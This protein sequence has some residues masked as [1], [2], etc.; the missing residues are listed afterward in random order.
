MNFKEI[1]NKYLETIEVQDKLILM[2]EKTR[3]TEYEKYSQEI[4]NVLKF[5]NIANPYY[6]TGDGFI[7][8]DE[9]YSA[10]VEGLFRFSPR[11]VVSGFYMRGTNGNNGSKYFAYGYY[12]INAGFLL[13]E[14][15]PISEEEFLENVEFVT[16]QIINNLPYK[17]DIYYREEDDWLDR[18][19]TS[20]RKSNIYIEY[21]PEVK[22]SIVNKN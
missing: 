5:R 7:K 22:A 11:I 12:D 15:E 10:N 17:P 2:A 16:K 21:Y 20:A 6:K 19:V 1:T 3:A 8:I 14:L 13:S 9:I 4:I 18:I